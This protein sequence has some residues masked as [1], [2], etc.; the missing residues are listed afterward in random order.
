[1]ILDWP[2]IFSMTDN[3]ICRYF[4][5]IPSDE[6]ITVTNYP[7]DKKKD[8]AK[9][10]DK[11]GFANAIFNFHD[12][13]K[14]PKFADEYNCVAAQDILTREYKLEP[15]FKHPDLELLTKLYQT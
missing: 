13:M 2:N 15:K 4:S 10:K 1:M 11:Q 5:N 6:E 8:T 12:W 7:I 9:F 14:W 3:R